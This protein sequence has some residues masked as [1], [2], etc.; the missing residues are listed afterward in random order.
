M[1]VLHNFHACL[2][3]NVCVCAYKHT[4][5]FISYK[6]I[7]YFFLFGGKFAKAELNP[8]MNLLHSSVI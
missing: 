6:V 4:D 5:V 7:K 1:K 8:S 2:C 3:V